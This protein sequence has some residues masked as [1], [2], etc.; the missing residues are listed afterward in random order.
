MLSRK[1]RIKIIKNNFDLINQYI[2]K[3]IMSLENRIIVDYDEYD[4]DISE[5]PY[6]F[7]LSDTDLKLEFFLPR[8]GKQG[9]LGVFSNSKNKKYVFKISQH[10]NFT[11]RAEG[12][13]M[14]S[15]KKI[16]DFCPNF[17][18]GF[19]TR[20]ILLDA[21]YREEKNPFEI[22]A[23]YPIYQDVLMM[24]NLDNCRKFYRYIKSKKVEN[25][26]IFSIIKQTLCAVSIAQKNCQFTHYDLHSN[27]VL[28][29]ECDPNT[30]ILYR[31]DENKSFIFPTYGF[32][33]I[34]I[35]YGFSYSDEMKTNPVY[36]A[37]AHT[38][39][40]FMSDRYDHTSDPRLFLTTVSWEL[41]RYKKDGVAWRLRKLVKNIFKPI[42]QDWDCGWDD[43]DDV[44]ASDHA[45]AFLEEK[46][47][48]SKFF[49]N[50]GFYC[51]DILQA[52]I[53]S[54]LKERKYNKI[55]D[56][57]EIFYSEFI[58]IENEIGSDFY[59]LYI[60]KEMILAASKVKNEYINGD[61]QNA[62]NMFRHFMY[63]TFE[64]VSKYCNPKI[65]YEKLLCS[66]IL[67][68]KKVEGILY[69]VL[70]DR[71]KERDQQK[72]K[73]DIKSI[74]EIISLVEYNFSDSYKLDSNSN[75]I[76][77][78]NIK[79]QKYKVELEQEQLDEINSYDESVR[80]IILSNMLETN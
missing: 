53:D 5:L 31:L 21:N 73:M 75:I 6:Q 74:D 63:E 10:F 37:F 33:P 41:T 24:E 38:D 13:C 42:K 14:K 22:K 58:K 28:I 76:V 18:Y 80:G 54:P 25:E 34:I 29:G 43:V 20:K 16:Q 52:L 78:D 39:V 50:Y 46:M 60:F 40:G 17:C 30:F 26:V 71:H 11:M 59:L 67:L 62:V 23:K 2:F 44:S 12:L 79:K 4:A 68:A 3:I 77:I 47:K 8:T 19:G 45:L 56:A 15:L 64:Q 35:D 7:K 32:Y 1:F 48:M 70:E 69:D 57:F 49:D 55:D 36:Q 51:I 65:K 27:N 66:L 72:A 61:S 9:L